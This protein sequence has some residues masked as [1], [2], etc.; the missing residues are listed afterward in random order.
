MIEH[1]RGMSST[2]R[3]L[4]VAGHILTDKQ[5]VQAVIRSLP[6]S[7]L[8]MK[9]ILTNKENIKIFKYIS[10]HVELEAYR[11]VA[12]QTAQALPTKVN[13]HKI[14]GFK[15]KKGVNGAPKEGKNSEGGSKSVPKKNAKHRRGK[16]VEQKKS[17]AL[18]A[19]RR[20]TS[21]L[22]ALS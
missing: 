4:N 14:S 6:D 22:I 18:T 3:D 19:R 7:W 1:L 11:I 13:P 17:N 9:Q 20:G 8:H 12:N 5:Q 21:L 10:R 2:I 15:H 16:S